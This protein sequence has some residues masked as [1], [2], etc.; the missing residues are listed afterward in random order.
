MQMNTVS[1]IIFDK[2]AKRKLLSFLQSKNK[3][4]LSSVCHEIMDYIS[5]HEAA[6]IAF[7]NQCQ[8]INYDVGLYFLLRKE[9]CTWHITDTLFI[10]K[11][12]TY[13]PI[14]N[15]TQF[16]HGSYSL[17][18][19]RIIGWRMAFLPVVAIE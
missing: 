19:R 8:E 4:K 7:D 6:G 9:N 5:A 2:A 12:Y 1:W 15:W 18:C 17:L 11:A 10:R 16:H 14:Y 3:Q 13:R